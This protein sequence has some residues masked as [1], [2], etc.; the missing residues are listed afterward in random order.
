[1]RTECLLVAGGDD[2]TAISYAAGSSTN[3]YGYAPVPFTSTATSTFIP[4]G[5]Y[6]IILLFLL[7]QM[8]R[9]R[10]TLSHVTGQ[11]A[12]CKGAA[13]V[14]VV[15]RVRCVHVALLY[16]HTLLKLMTR[17]HLILQCTTVH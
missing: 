1:V 11:L 8:R 14:L 5:R 4:R 15:V 13:N 6:I 17:L 10:N 12:C 16:P 3:K 2:R 7:F 9:K